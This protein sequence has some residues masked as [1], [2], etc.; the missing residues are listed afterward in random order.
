MTALP[1]REGRWGSCGCLGPPLLSRAAPL[2]WRLEPP[3]SLGLERGHPGWRPGGWKGS[4][5]L[6]ALSV[7]EPEGTEN[8][9]NGWLLAP[10]QHVCACVGRSES[11]DSGLGWGWKFQTQDQ[12][13]L[14][15]VGQELSWL[16]GFLVCQLTRWFLKSRSFLDPFSVILLIPETRRAE[17]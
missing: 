2:P 17:G 14:S 4:H 16:W 6:A 5:G 8:S 13:G 10:P 7:S 11:S 1:P 12:E 9:G 15:Q 3:L